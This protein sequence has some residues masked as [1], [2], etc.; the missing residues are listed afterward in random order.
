MSAEVMES[1]L[2][3]CSNE[4]IGT[5]EKLAWGTSI[6]KWKAAESVIF[7]DAGGNVICR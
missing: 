7:A 5:Q 1:D 3:L 6:V 2:E 4:S